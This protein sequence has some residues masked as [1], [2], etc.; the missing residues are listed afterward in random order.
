MPDYVLMRWPDG[1]FVAASGHAHSYVREL[2]YARVWSSKEAADHE[3]CPENE[4]AVP[5]DAVMRVARERLEEPRRCR[6]CDEPMVGRDAARGYWI[7]RS[8]QR[9]HRV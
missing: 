1:K 8:C 2:Q 4:I 7:C 5:V 6:K 3:R 9:L